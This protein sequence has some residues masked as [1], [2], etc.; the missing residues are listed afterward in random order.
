[1]RRSNSTLMRKKNMVVLYTFTIQGTYI[2][3][4][5]AIV[6]LIFGKFIKNEIFFVFTASSESL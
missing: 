5:V 1:M 2:K 6:L 3:K 4:K